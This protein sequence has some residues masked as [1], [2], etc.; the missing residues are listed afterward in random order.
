MVSGC[1]LIRGLELISGANLREH[2][3]IKNQKLDTFEKEFMVKE[4]L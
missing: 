2:L 1:Q 4:E 3:V